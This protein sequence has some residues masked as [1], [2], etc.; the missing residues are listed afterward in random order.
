MFQKLESHTKA[1]VDDVFVQC[2]LFSPGRQLKPT[3]IDQ[4]SVRVSETFVHHEGKTLSRESGKSQ[5]QSC[6]I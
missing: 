3:V 5:R 1:L 4:A 6:S 2:N